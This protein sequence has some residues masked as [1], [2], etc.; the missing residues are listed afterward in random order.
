M[1]D[2]PSTKVK[3][4]DPTIPHERKPSKTYITTIVKGAE[5]SKLP[6]SYVQFL[7]NI[8][9]NGREAYPELIEKLKLDCN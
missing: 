9:H 6:E 8:A 4:K 3:L 5:E 7:K 1:T 2:T